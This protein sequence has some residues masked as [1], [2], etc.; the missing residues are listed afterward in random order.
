MKWKH[1]QVPDI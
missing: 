1:G